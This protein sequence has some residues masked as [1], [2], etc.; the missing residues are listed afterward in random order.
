MGP[1]EE[2][3]QRLIEAATRGFAEHGVHTASLLE[4]TR[5]AGQRNRGAVHYHFGSRTGMLVAVLEQPLDALAAREQELIAAARECPDD[6]LVSV[7]RA[8]VLPAIE[9]AELGGLGRSYLMILGELVEE[10]R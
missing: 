4:I 1:A 9:L 2:T 8:L 7:V 5:Q 10:D 6:D 3:R